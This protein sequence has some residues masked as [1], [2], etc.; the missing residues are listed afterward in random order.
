[1]SNVLSP[2]KQAL[3]ISC[4]VEGM[5]LRATAR[6]T[7]THRTTILNLL[8]D[9]GTWAAEYCDKVLRDLPCKRLELDEA[10]SF[11]YVKEVNKPR[12]THAPP[13]LVMSGRGLLLTR[14]RSSSPRGL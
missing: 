2:R 11:V 7:D 5:S 3:V 6:V 14:I 4:L 13:R 1:M 9:A 10:W 8:R 12:A